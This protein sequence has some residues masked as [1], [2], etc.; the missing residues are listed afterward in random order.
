VTFGFF[1]VRW[2]LFYD[3]LTGVMFVVVSTIS[4]MVHLYSLGY[5]A[6]DPQ[7]PLFLAYLGL[8]TFFMLLL[9]SASNFIQLFIG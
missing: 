9:V 7:K 6:E 4:L 1:D 8:F 3:P 5:M 2:S